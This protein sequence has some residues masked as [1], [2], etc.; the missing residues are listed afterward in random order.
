M[1]SFVHLLTVAAI[2]VHATFGCCAHETHEVEVTASE[3]SECG[4]CH[5][6]SSHQEE[7]EQDDHSQDDL[8]HDDLSQKG[9][10]PVPHECSHADCKWPAPE[11]RTLTDF[12]LLSSMGILPWN[13]TNSLASLFGNASDS[14]LL[15]PDLASPTL[16]VRS[17]LALCVLLI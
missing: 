8:A 14:S 4:C 3:S 13:S 10:Q 9:Q 12:E 11:A 7:H 17:H 6:H 15:L 16:P 1:T 2:F 5:H